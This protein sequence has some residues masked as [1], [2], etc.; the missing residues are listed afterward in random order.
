MVGVGSLNIRN[1]AATH[2]A[3]AQSSSEVMSIRLS[4]AWP[5]PRGK[6]SANSA[7][8]PEPQLSVAERPD[9]VRSAPSDVG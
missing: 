7:C 6:K 3:G 1:S 2:A 5:A 4:L 8:T 9:D